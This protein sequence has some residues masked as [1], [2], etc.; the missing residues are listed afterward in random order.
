MKRMMA[1]VSVVV[2]LAAAGGFYAWQHMGRSGSSELEAWIGRLLVRVLQSYIEPE[3]TFTAIDYEAPLTVQIDGL[4]VVDDGVV[5]IAV[6]RARLTLTDVPRVGEP[7]EI[8]SVE[9]EKPVLEFQQRADGTFVGWMPFVK[10]EVVAKPASVPQ[11]QR[12]SDV[13]ALREVAISDG[14]LR[15][16]DADPETASMVLPEVNMDLQAVPIAG[17][18]GWY[19]LE[20]TIGRQPVFRVGFD[21]R[22]NVD[23]ATVRVGLLS[24]E[25]ALGDQ[26]YESLPPQLQSFLRKH[27][28]RGAL[29]AT[30]RGTV[31]LLSP[32][33][34]QGSAQVELT[35]FR[36]TDQKREWVVGRGVLEVETVDEAP[37]RARGV[38]DVHDSRLV[39]LP[40]IVD[41]VELLAAAALGMELP[42]ADKAQLE[43]AVHDERVHVNK[44]EI[45][46]TVVALRGDGDVFYDG[47]LDLLV[48]AGALEKV[49][50][51]LGLVGDVFGVLSD[52][53]VR[54]QVTGTVEEPELKVRPLGVG[55]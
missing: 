52:K 18:P 19:G 26:Q 17:E 1:I 53:L 22:L 36:L 3:V 51:K 6:E 31:P 30:V 54:Y 44:A 55:G 21:G 9:L 23:T 35:G 42:A 7:V 15:Y 33:A 40:I 14:E 50:S 5:I 25:A 49:Q 34:A 41:F 12:F 38:V 45:T 4:R 10:Q 2:V 16:D 46:S 43:F 20:A 13:L 24:V 29:K 48:N 37:P 11:G 32:A 47:R 27:R 39:Y 8:A 28:A